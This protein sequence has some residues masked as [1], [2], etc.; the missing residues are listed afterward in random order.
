M[1][2]IREQFEEIWPV[3][4][5]IYWSD[6]H[7]QYMIKNGAGT[8]GDCLSY[9]VKLDIFTR[10]Q[11]TTSLFMDHV[12]ELVYELEHCH[13]NGG[14]SKDVVARAKQILGRKK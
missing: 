11:E 3:P 6:I 5:C 7:G 14:Y 10:C 8:L 12:G 4:E 9:E 2:S 1:K 13:V